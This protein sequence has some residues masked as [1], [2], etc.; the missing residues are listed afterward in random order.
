[1]NLD[2]KTLI[3]KLNPTCRRALEEAAGLCVGHTHY[4]VEIEH[5]ISKLLEIPD[6]QDTDLRRAL[7]QYDVDRNAVSREITDSLSRFDRGNSRTP[8]FSPQLLQLLREAWTTS[9]LQLQTPAI[10]TG[11]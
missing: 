3:D 11:S 9:T 8:A 10:R 2:L 6:I 5:L 7:R 4:N 1:M